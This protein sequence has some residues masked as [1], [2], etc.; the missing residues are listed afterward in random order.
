[1]IIGSKSIIKEALQRLGDQSLQNMDISHMSPLTSTT[2]DINA[3]ARFLNIHFNI[4][5]DKTIHSSPY[6]G[7]AVYLVHNLTPLS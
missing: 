2:S 1:M 3:F 4:P 7:Y 5:E 6:K